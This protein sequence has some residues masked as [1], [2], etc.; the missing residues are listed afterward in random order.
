MSAK[1]LCI[2][3]R[4]CI[5]STQGLNCTISFV[6]ILEAAWLTK[7]LKERILW[8]EKK[9]LSEVRHKVSENS[10]CIVLVAVILSPEPHYFP[11]CISFPGDLPSDQQPQPCGR[12]GV[13]STNRVTSV[14]LAIDIHW[15]LWSLQKCWCELFG[16]QWGENGHTVRFTPSSRYSFSGVRHLVNPVLSDGCFRNLCSF[17]MPHDCCKSWSLKGKLLLRLSAMHVTARKGC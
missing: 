11:V 8:Y 10:F 16:R 5:K 13:L 14:C 6:W 4:K 2:L 7:R 9:N 17:E 15:L 3:E 12:V 1:W